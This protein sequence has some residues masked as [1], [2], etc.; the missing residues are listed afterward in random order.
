MTACTV[1][2]ITPAD[3]RAADATAYFIATGDGPE[4]LCTT[5]IQYADLHR[6]PSILAYNNRE[7]S[8]LRAELEATRERLRHAEDAASLFADH[9]K[10]CQPTTRETDAVAEWEYAAGIKAA[11]DD[12][13]EYTRARDMA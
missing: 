9:L 6:L 3:V 2:G 11:I 8:L 4:L 5:C 1:C 10:G 7:M 13:D 12:A